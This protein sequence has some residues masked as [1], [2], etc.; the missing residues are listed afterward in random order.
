M[1]YKEQNEQQIRGFLDSLTLYT[2]CTFRNVSYRLT[3][4]KRNTR[5]RRRRNRPTRVRVCVCQ[6][7]RERLE[8][9]NT[10]YALYLYIIIIYILY[11]YTSLPSTLYTFVYLVREL[12]KVSSGTRERGENC[13]SVL[14]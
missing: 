8:A 14:Q 3:E 7:E 10:I 2:L 12:P 9:E 1:T 6:I 11:T 5:R 4:K 13:E